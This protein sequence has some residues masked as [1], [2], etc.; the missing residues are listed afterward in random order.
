MNSNNNNNQ[1]SNNG[2]IISNNTLMN[3]QIKT[4]KISVMN[5]RII[6]VKKKH[7]KIAYIS[8]NKGKKKEGRKYYHKA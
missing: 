6:L 2:C 3:P 7:V 8:S 5:N 1:W 4:T